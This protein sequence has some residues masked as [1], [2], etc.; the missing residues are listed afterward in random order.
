MVIDG[1][2]DAIGNPGV[3]AVA[4]VGENFDRHQA[5]M[6]TNASDTEKVVSGSGGDAGDVGAMA[7]EVGGS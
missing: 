3:I 5:G 1:V 7:D 6:V 2:V 4:A